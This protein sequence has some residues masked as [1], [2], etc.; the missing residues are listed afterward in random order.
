MNARLVSK[1]PPTSSTDRSIWV[2]RLP[3]SCITT[4]LVRCVVYWYPLQYFV[5]PVLY[6]REPGKK[7]AVSQG[8]EC[9]S[10][11]V[12]VNCIANAA[13]LGHDMSL[14]PEDPSAKRNPV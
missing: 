8:S 14:A 5:K 1:V 12:A 2:T 4:V 6:V 3:T 10:V 9:V 11:L 7:V 13:Q